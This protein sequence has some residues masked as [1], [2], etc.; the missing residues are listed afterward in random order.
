MKRRI[1]VGLCA[2]FILLPL[3]ALQTVEQ[4]LPKLNAE[5]LAILRSGEQLETSNL[6]G[7]TLLP[8]VPVGTEADRKAQKSEVLTDGFAVASVALIPYPE[9]WKNMDVETREL[10]IFNTMRKVST[11][12]GI[13][14]ISHRAGDKPRTLFKKSY[15]ISDPEDKKS[16]IP[17]PVVDKV[18]TNLISYVYQEDTSFGGNIYRHAYTNNDEELFLDVTNFTPMKFM[19]ITCV[20][21]HQLSMCM[22]S[23]QTDEGILLYSM[24]TI[25]GQKPQVQ[26]LFISVDLP[27]SFLKRVTSLRN[28][29][30]AQLAEV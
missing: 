12:A 11:Q 21:A 27:S 2:L 25:Q 8:F 23:C 20:K 6:D 4:A 22:S 16:Q 5:Q 18:P 10:A 29:F 17:D 19:G 9:A 14:Y 30:K 26:I 15:Y 28:W 13:T 7:E 1:L 3:S 24:A